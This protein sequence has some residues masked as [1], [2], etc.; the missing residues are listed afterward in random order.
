LEWPS[1]WDALWFEM[2]SADREEEDENDELSSATMIR[3][4]DHGM[5]ERRR[6]EIGRKS[7]RVRRHG[8]VSADPPTGRYPI[9]AYCGRRGRCASSKSG[10]G[11]SNVFRVVEIVPRRSITSLPPNQ[12]LL[13]FE[14]SR[15]SI[16]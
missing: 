2:P 5:C 10:S 6:M 14:A 4:S 3:R 1:E 13:T 11:A 7:T 12:Q 8:V 15:M 16:S 9:S